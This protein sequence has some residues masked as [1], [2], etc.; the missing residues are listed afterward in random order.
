[1]MVNLLVFITQCLYQ[2]KITPK[3][4]DLFLKSKYLY[5]S[6]LSMKKLAVFAFLSIFLFN[7]VGYYIVFL[8]NQTEVKKE[9]A[10]Q[11]KFGVSS[12][13]IATFTFNKNQ[14]ANIVWQKKNK[15]FYH[16]NK[17]YDVVSINEINSSIV[18]Q[19][20]SDIE[21]ENLFEDLEKHIDTFIASNESKKK[22]NSKKLTDHVIKLYF[23]QSS[24]F[25]IH[26]S[27]LKNT[28]STY[29]LSYTSEYSEINSPP[30]EFS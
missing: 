12:L 21:E 2:R 27:I 25:N 19:C 5:L 30:P 16:N 18:I 28:F 15:E 17:L 24:Q 3:R 11:M 1:M 26:S 10:Y 7:S 6:H 22:S 23:S 8:I 29:K 14:L 4:H 9:M 20:I 13:K